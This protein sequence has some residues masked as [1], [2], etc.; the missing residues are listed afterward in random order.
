M[1]S[2]LGIVSRENFCQLAYLHFVT[3]YNNIYPISL[4]SDTIEIKS[5][6]FIV[7]DYCPGRY[8]TTVCQK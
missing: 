3:F 1:S 4:V 5:T 8:F 6:V 2:D 7:L